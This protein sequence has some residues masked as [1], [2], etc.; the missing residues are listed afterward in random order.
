VFPD[1]E[2]RPLRGGVVNER[3]TKCLTAAGLPKMTSQPFVIHFGTPLFL[4]GHLP[5]RSDALGIENS[6]DE[7]LPPTPSHPARRYSQR[8]HMMGKRVGN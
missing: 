2:G 7:P 8:N 1:L 3:L 4:A 6:G 5:L